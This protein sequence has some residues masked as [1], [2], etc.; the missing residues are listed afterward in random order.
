MARFIRFHFV[1]LLSMLLGISTVSAQETDAEEARMAHAVAVYYEGTNEVEFYQAINNYRDYLK[2][3]GDM[4]QYYEAWEKEIEYDIQHNHFRTALKKT[5][6]LK[7]ELKEAKAEDYY[8]LID[9]LMGVF[10]GMREENVQAKQHLQQAALL[11]DSEKAREALLQIYQTLANVCIFKNLEDGYEGYDWADKAFKISETPEEQCSS[12]SLKAMVAFGHNDR[13]TFDQCYN[14]I[15]KLRQKHSDRELNMFG[16]YVLMGRVTYNGD[17][18]EAVAICDSIPDEVGRLYFLATIYD[19]KGDLQQ[20]RDALFDLL[21]AKDRRNNE[22]STLTVNDLDKDFL[23]E[24]ERMKTQR[25]QLYVYVAIAVIVA[26]TVL[27]FFV[28]R[29]RWR[30]KREERQIYKNIWSDNE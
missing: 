6:Q 21:R 9:Y 3:K 16:K 8:Y 5:E 14:E 1:L 2:G 11:A 12:L 4:R 22:I 23:L 20:E 19:I 13:R 10:Y 18:E 17:Y 15:V 25:I 26:I 27:L 28:L 24:Q 7:N 29:A 30:E